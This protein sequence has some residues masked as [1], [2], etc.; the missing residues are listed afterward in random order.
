MSLA[1]KRV[2]TAIVFLLLQA[3]GQR[4]DAFPTG[5]RSGNPGYLIGKPLLV[6]TGDFRH[7]VSFLELGGLSQ[8]DRNAA[9][10]SA[11]LVLRVPSGFGTQHFLYQSILHS[12][13]LM[14]PKAS[15]LGLAESEDCT[16]F[17]L[18]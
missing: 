13:M 11:F 5:P 12:H 9:A 6:L 7:S 8:S 10:V 15:Q 2:C 17:C 3:F 16:D 4:M 1:G 18:F 14:P